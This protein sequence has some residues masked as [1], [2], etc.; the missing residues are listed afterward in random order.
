M[1]SQVFGRVSHTP[2]GLPAYAVERL[3]MQLRSER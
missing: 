3:S 2:A 1:E